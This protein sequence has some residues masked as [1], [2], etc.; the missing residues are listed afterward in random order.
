MLAAGVSTGNSP[1]QIC[2]QEHSM[3]GMRDFQVRE[4]NIYWVVSE[5]TL[6]S[7][8]YRD[9]HC[10]NVRVIILGVAYGKFCNCKL[11]WW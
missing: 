5:D 11:I 9:V 10:I 3:M 6:Y 1:T 7:V 8:C 2:L 4:W